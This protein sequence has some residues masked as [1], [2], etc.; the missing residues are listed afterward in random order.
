MYTSMMPCTTMMMWMRPMRRMMSAACRPPA[1]N[2]TKQELP[3]PKTA[4]VPM[5][6]IDTALAAGGFKK[7][8]SAVIA[9]GLGET[10]QGSGPFTVFA[11]ADS[12]FAEL[13]AGA[14]EDLLKPENK[15]RLKAVL[16][17]HVAAGRLTAGDLANTQKLMT[18][19][20]KEIP[21]RV[22]I[23]LLAGSELRGSLRVGSARVTTADIVCT[24]GVIHVVDQ[25]LIPAD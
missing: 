16:T 7:L 13:P 12:A 8:I 5:N 15:E 2:Q 17:W 19:S 3:A 9:G 10:L 24:N 20:G 6:I 21:V 14:L 1:S 23:S 4:P 11:P 18:V 25:V 22:D